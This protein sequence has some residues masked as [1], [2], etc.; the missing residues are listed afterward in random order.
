MLIPEANDFRGFD[1]LSLGVLACDR[2]SLSIRFANA[3]AKGWFG[4]DIV[5]RSLTSVIP[6]LVQ[7]DA[8][9]AFTEGR[10]FTL[11]GEFA[12]ASGGRMA[13]RLFISPEPLCQDL[14]LAEVEDIT[15]L[16]EQEHLLESYSRMVER[17]TREIQKE[18]ER[19]EKLLMNIFPYSVLKEFKEFGTT[20][21]SFYDDVSVMFL[22][23][24]GFTRM[25]I[26]KQP[27]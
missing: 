6:D 25:P 21:P 4:S 12:P 16:K 9:Q 10:A 17:K 20:T 24:V 1:L 11:A 3:R 7:S 2:E 27:K 8:T 15:K 23:F 22:D 19:A 18:Q 14:L 26:S 13:F 5:G